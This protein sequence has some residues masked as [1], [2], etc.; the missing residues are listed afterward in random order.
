MLRVQFHQ[1]CDHVQEFHARQIDTSYM[2]KLHKV[3]PH[4]HWGRDFEFRSEKL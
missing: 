2:A 1:T 3:R 4:I